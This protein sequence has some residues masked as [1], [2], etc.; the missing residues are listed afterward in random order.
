MPPVSHRLKLFTRAGWFPVLWCVCIASTSFA[1]SLPNYITRVWTTDDGLPGSSIMTVIQSHDGYL[2]LGT[3][4]GLAR[5][6]GARFTIFDGGNTP[7]MQRSHMTCLFEDAKGTIWMGHQTGE[8][9]AYQDGKFHAV[10]IKAKWHS[11]R[12]YAISADQAGDVWLLNGNG[13]L[14][15]MKDW[16]VIPSPP[17]KTPVRLTLTMK[18]KGGFWIQR[19]NEVWELVAGQL[20]PVHFDEPPVNRYI[21]GIGASLDGGLWVM[22]GSRMRK[23]KDAQWVEDWGPAPWEWGVV[24]TLLERKDGSLAAATS[25]HGLYLVFPG[26]GSLQ[27]CRTNGFPDDWITSSLCEDHEGNLWVGTGNSGL[28]MLRPGNI[29]TLNPPD[30]W[31]GHAVLSVTAGPDGALWIGTEGASLY[32]FHDGSWTNLGG[33]VGLNHRYVWSVVLDAQGRTWAGTWGGSLFWGNESRFELLP[34]LKDF[35]AP[36]PALLALPNGELL[37][38]TGIGLMQYEPG[39]ITW[40]A[41]EPEFAFPDVRTVIETPDGTLWFGMFG[42]GLGRLQQGTLRQ[43]RRSDGLSSDFVRCLHLASDGTLWIGT[44]NGLNRLKD[45]RFVA[46]TKKQGL[47]DD[48]ICAIEDDG[49][50]Y[51]WL[52]SHSGIMRVSQTELNRCADGQV[53]QLHCLT[54]GRSDGLP[55]LEC[56]GGFQPASCQTADGRLWFPTSKGLVAVD[57]GYVRT[58]TLVPPVVIERLLVDDR[59]VSEGTAPKPPLRIAPG[60]HR[61]EFQFTCLSFAAPEKVRFRYRLD[62]VETKWVETQSPRKA[63]YTHLPPGNYR[64]RVLACNNDGVWNETGATLAF[65]VEPAFWQTWWFRAAGGAMLVLAGGGIAWLDARRRMRRKL[66]RLERQQVVERERIRIA[67]DIHDDLGANLTRITMLSE[68]ARSGLDD[69]RQVAGHL[70]QIHNTARELTRA[71]GEVVWAVNPRHDTLDSVAAYLEEFGQSL[72]R[73]AGIR[74]KMNMPSQFPA[75]VITAEVRHNLFLAFKEALHNAIKH[76]GASEVRISLVVEPAAFTLAVE[77]NGKG[78]VSET[79]LAGTPGGLPRHRAGNGLANMRQRLAEIGGH[80]EIESAPGKGTK[81]TFT[82]ALKGRPA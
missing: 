20:R 13:E 7:E 82:V 65:T 43:F 77:D 12:I 22:T 62:G 50:G 26:Q 35:H 81:V 27:F 44:F 48:I 18:P 21:Q 38:G 34:E 67:K 51:F 4:S 54:Y 14:A 68:S 15:R 10:P 1:A 73:T 11:G 23:W 70:D 72:L 71:M 47:S 41:R 37:I 9:T 16:F 53:T 74:C 66:E 49:R 6:D 55:T 56:S 25:D 46:I 45:G 24:H 76:A 2:W 19:D 42:G 58:N 17:G 39:K 28:A 59:V 3:P 8:L 61:F 32:R 30:Q 78:F 80:C 5:F 63:Y 69:S 31:R 36:I 64:F 40:L 33:N 60:W 75:R 57:P 52:S 79:L 29:T